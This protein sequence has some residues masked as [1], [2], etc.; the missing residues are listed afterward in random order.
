METPQ[1]LLH[2]LVTAKTDLGCV[3]L[4]SPCPER[5]IARLEGLDGS[6]NGPCTSEKGRAEKRRGHC[7][8]PTQQQ[9]HERRDR[10]KLSTF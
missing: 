6:R 3:I 7:Q 4:W 9:Q 8:M 5:S 2:A 10:E 1:L